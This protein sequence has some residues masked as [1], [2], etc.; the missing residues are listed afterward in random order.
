MIRIRNIS[1]SPVHISYDGG[2]YLLSFNASLT[3]NSVIYGEELDEILLKSSNGL[4]E[5]VLLDELFDADFNL[6]D[7]NNVSDSITDTISRFQNIQ[8]LRSDKE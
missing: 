6:L 1:S 7:H 2:S 4:I 8:L 3:F 5:L